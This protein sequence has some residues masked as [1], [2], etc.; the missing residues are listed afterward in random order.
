MQRQS[1]VDISY[2]A[3]KG[4]KEVQTY[5]IFVKTFT[6]GSTG[7]FLKLSDEIFQNPIS[8]AALTL[9][10]YSIVRKT[11]PIIPQRFIS[12]PPNPTVQCS[13]PGPVGCATIKP[14]KV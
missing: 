4:F 7:E 3:I 1:C 11:T 10:E 9:N 5:N 12:T 8:T 6:G 14:A 13:A 2:H